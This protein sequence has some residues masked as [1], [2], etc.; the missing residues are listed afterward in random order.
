MAGS[1]ISFVYLVT[2]WLVISLTFIDT[3]GSHPGSVGMPSTAI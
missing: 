2:D 3:S 1:K